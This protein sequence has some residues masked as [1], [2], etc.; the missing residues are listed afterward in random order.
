M[1]AYVCESISV[2]TYLCEMD[3]PNFINRLSFNLFRYC[4]QFISLTEYVITNFKVYI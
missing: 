1:N 3:D 2:S 4:G